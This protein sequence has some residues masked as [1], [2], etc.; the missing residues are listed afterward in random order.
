MHKKLLIAM[1]VPIFAFSLVVTGCGSDDGVFDGAPTH[2]AFSGSWVNLSLD[3]ANEP[4][5][6]FLISATQLALMD[7]TD[8]WN[9]P[10]YEGGLIFR[11]GFRET[12]ASGIRETT[13]PVELNHIS[14][15]LFLQAANRWLLAQQDG[16]IATEEL[17]DIIDDLFPG[18]LDAMDN[19][20]NADYNELNLAGNVGVDWPTIAGIN[21][22]LV[23]SEGIRLLENWFRGQLG[24]T[25]PARWHNEFVLNAFVQND[26]FVD[27]LEAL[28]FQSGMLE[29][30]NT[31]IPLF[32][33]DDVIDGPER[34]VPFILEVHHW[35]DSSS[36]VPMHGIW[37]DFNGTP[38]GQRLVFFSTQ[39]PDW[40]QTNMPLPS[41]V[42][43]RNSL[44]P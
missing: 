16:G 20:Y 25:F 30:L 2:R 43:Q 42:F 10:L 7:V 31:T 21:S 4:I 41:G 38:E 8:E 26:D 15:H 12:A 32:N 3:P 23:N 29:E 5:S 37:I 44:A 1:L 34:V 6:W 17:R 22:H 40:W 36:Y 27:R 28:G 33:L 11:T 19:L 9:L 13:L 24:L 39:A 14:Q 35:E 18:F